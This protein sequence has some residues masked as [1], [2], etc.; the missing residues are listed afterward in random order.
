[1]VSNEGFNALSTFRDALVGLPLS[2]L[3]RGY[4]S[5][6]FLEFGQLTPRTRRSGDAGNPKG[7]FGL[8]IQWSWRIENRA[9]I[10]CGSWSDEALWESTF[11]LLRNK[12]V[13]DISIMGR[14]PEV[15]VALA[16]DHYISSFMTADGD[17]SWTLFDRRGDVGRWLTVREGRLS[18]ELAPRQ[19]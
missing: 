1:M 9:S 11:D 10:L 17:P 2:Y 5:A 18:I 6:I 4:G 19:E 13:V 15:V 7:E 14:L 3:W 16:E 12:A 8:M